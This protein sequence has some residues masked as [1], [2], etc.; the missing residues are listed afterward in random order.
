ML[1]RW[2]DHALRHLDNVIATSHIGYVS[3]ELYRIFYQDTVA[4][5]DNWLEKKS[6]L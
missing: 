4:N 6:R 5:I 1:S 2:Q 3:G